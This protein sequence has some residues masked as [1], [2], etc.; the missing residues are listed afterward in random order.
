MELRLRERCALLLMARVGL[1]DKL[2]RE[3]YRP[4]VRHDVARAGQRDDDVVTLHFNVCFWHIADM[5]RVSERVCFR[6]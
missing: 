4:V 1:G 5:G 6:G 2:L 3:G